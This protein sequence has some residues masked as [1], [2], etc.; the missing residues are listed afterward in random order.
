[1]NKT[2]L[3]LGEIFAL[4]GELNGTINQQT[5]ERLTKGILSQQ[6]P[7]LQKYWLG[8][9]NDEIVKLK[10]NID[11]LRDELVI[12]FGVADDKGGYA[13]P[14]STDKLDKEGNPVLNDAGEVI[15]EINPNF[16]SFNKE[17]N[18]LLEETREIE[19]YP[20]K[21]ENLDFT[22]YEFYPVFLKLLKP[23][24]EDSAK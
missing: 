4:E 9:L 21:L 20:F 24:K 13:I 17:L 11:K 16:E 14:L 10:K 2:S 19:Y 7:L 22:S 18:I 1:M 8:E 5:G 15:K 3:N 23:K 6:L 12:K